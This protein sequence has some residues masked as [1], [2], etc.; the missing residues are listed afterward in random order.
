MAMQHKEPDRVPLFYRDVPE[1]R[2]RLLRDLQ[3]EDDEALF[4]LLGI[5]FRWGAPE[6]LGADLDPAP[7]RRRDIWGVA[8]R[9]VPFSDAAGYW[10]PVARPLA[11]CTDLAALDDYPWPSVEQ[12]DFT[13]LR[14]Q[15]T[16]ASGFA[17]MTGP[18]FA[19]PGIL[20]YPI[21]QL[22][23]EERSFLDMALRAD[24]FDAL[25]ERVLA[26]QVPFIERMLD[27]AGGGIDFFR[28][29]DDYGT[30]RGL[31]VGLDMWRARIRPAL[32]AMYEA[33][34]RHGALCYQHSCG[35]VRALI[36]DLV[37]IGVD[38]LDPLQVQAGGMVPAELKAEFG[39]RM[40][41]S[42]GVDEQ[43]LLPRGSPADV[44]DAVHRLLDIMAPGGGF[45]L[46]PT[47]NFQDDVPTA[48]IVAL[49]E[50]AR[51]WSA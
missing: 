29:G 4:R 25:V 12:F 2:A 17:V 23:G 28:V 36:P 14:R 16:R 49:Y 47:H 7:G 13:T 43:E 9:Y 32:Q 45:F 11:D 46:G 39:E 6:Y 38:V 15:V 22:L 34:K 24:F 26:F 21:Q 44:R 27:A 18:G 35:G 48:N 30:Q 40:V 50:A 31:M 3:C 42:G 1:V 20:Q 33:A 5:D 8:Y 41:F 51:E 19:S 37:E 10:E